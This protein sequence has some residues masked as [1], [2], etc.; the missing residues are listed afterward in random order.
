VSADERRLHHWPFLFPQPRFAVGELLQWID[1]L[2]ES[3]IPGS[4]KIEQ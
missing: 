1:R 3:I 2:I 4:G